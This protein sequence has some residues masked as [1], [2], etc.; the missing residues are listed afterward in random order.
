[1]EKE[2]ENAN[3]VE[4]TKESL[5]TAENAPEKEEAKIE[6][7]AEEAKSEAPAVEKPRSEKKKSRKKVLQGTVVSNKGD[8]T[9]VVKVERLVAH[10]LY[11]KY[12]R[13]SKK[14]M[15]HDPNNECGIGDIARIEESRP[16][17]AR[18]RWKLVEIVE[19]A[20]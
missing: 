12:Y 20:K 7:P 9:I 1:M 2:L 17:S 16:L 8:K 4:E 5:E 18:K 6:T 13:K 3:N 11:K 10:P 14:F 19:K 15:A